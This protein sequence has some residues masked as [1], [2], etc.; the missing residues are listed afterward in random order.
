MWPQNCNPKSIPLWARD[1]LVTQKSNLRL[2]LLE[3]YTGPWKP[4]TGAIEWGVPS[5]REF[6]G[7]VD[8]G[9]VACWDGSNPPF[10]TLCKEGSL[11]LFSRTL[12][13]NGKEP[14]WIHHPGTISWDSS[15]SIL[16]V[17]FVCG[18]AWTLGS[19]PASWSAVK[20][21]V[22]DCS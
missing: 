5:G 19:T 7:R 16:F 14:H 1:W 20:S 21:A 13:L 22:L 15:G 9:R 6:P 10:L 12:R 3:N 4:S 2:L 8:W 18:G 11:G 17:L